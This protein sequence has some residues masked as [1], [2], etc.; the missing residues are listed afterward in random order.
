MRRRTRTCVLVA[1]A[2]LLC[3]SNASAETAAFFR[4]SIGVGNLRTHSSGAPTPPSIT[5]SMNRTTFSSELSVGASRDH[6]LVFALTFIEHIVTVDRGYQTTSPLGG[7]TSFTLSLLGVTV[8]HHPVRRGGL[9]YGGTIGF[10]EHSLRIE[11]RP[12]GLG[13]A[14]Y[15]GWDLALSDRSSFGLGLRLLYARMSR[16]RAGGTL[17]QAFAPTI[18]LHYVFR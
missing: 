11:E 6:S 9:F 12:L 18:S 5:D 8:E 4:A 16:E 13:V 3:A 1:L 14:A 10:C 17:Y 2:S 7:D 15:G